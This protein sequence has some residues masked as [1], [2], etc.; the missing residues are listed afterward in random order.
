MNEIDFTHFLQRATTEDPY[1]RFLRFQVHQL[2]P[3]NV[4]LKIYIDPDFQANW[5]AVAHGAPLAAL[6]DACMGWSCRTLGYHVV[7]VNMDM[8]FLRPIPEETWVYG[9]GK[10][11]HRGKK[12]MV[13]E[14]RLYDQEHHLALFG[15]GTYW[16]H[17]EIDLKTDI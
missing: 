9:E 6:S 11:V 1:F 2:L 15:K 8:S 17:H 4:V 7:T 3:G 16:I 5:R 10:V 12:T 14:A 13:C